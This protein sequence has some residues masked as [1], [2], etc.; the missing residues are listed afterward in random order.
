MDIICTA[1]TTTINFSAT[2]PTEVAG[3]LDA[4]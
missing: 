3:G 4:L 2:G 1:T